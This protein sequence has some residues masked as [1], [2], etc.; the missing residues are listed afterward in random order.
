LDPRL[1]MPRGM[2]AQ[3]AA[4]AALAA[5]GL[6]CGHTAA[7]VREHVR[8]ALPGR[9][10]P[11]HRPGGLVRYVL[12]E[13][14]PLTPVVAAPVTAAPQLPR[15]ARMR[16]R[17]GRHTQPRLFLPVADE[18]LCRG[19]VTAGGRQPERGPQGATVPRSPYGVRRLR[20]RCFGRGP[21]SDRH[22]A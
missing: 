8:R 12:R 22:V 6:D 18:R 3:L 16:E 1:R 5:E 10:Q 4:L 17:E 19:P 20:V 11:I 9:G 15:V 7:A 21:P 14:P 13:V 2:L